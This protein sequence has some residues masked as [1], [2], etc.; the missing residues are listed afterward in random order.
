M[1]IFLQ[2]LRYA[3]RMLAK[4]PGFAVIAVLTLAIGIGANTAIFTV[5]DSVM[6]RP[7]PFHDPSRLVMLSEKSAQFEQ[8]SVSYPNFEDWRAQSHS[9]E[10]LAAFRRDSYTITGGALPEHI[11]GREVS[12]GFFSLLG[13]T[14][15]LGRDFRAEEDLQGAAPV[16]ILSYGLWQRRFGGDPGVLG[17][18]VNLSDTS[19]TVVGVLPHDFWFYSGADVFVPIGA[20]KAMWIHNRQMRN[21]MHA[22]AR[23]KPGVTLAQSRAEMDN[24]GRQLAA[25]YPDAN[26]RNGVSVLSVLEDVVSD[27]RGTLFLLFGA[28]GFLLLI[29]CVN[30]ANLLLSRVTPRQR[31]LA[32][33]SALGASTRRV[34]RQ[35]LTESVLLSLLGG[36]LG[37]GFAWLGTRLLVAAVPGTLPRAETIGMD[38]RVALFMLGLCFLTGI[39]FGMAPAWHAVRGN[40]SESLKE[41]GR[42]ASRSSHRVQNVLVVSELA[43]ALVLLVGAGLTIRTLQKLANVDPGFRSHDVLVFNAA[44]SQLR[45]NQP[46]KVRTLLHQV[47]DR[48]EKTPGFDAAAMTTDVVMRDDSEMNFYVTSRPKP[49]PQDMPWSMLYFTT[50]DYPQTMGLRL[51][52]GRFFSER[53]NL[54][55]PAVVVIDEEFARS[56]FPGQD[57]I[58]QHLA[59]PFP[60]LD[61]PR[62]IVGIVD[63]VKQWGLAQ[64]STA[65][66]R[67]QLYMPFLQVP[68][69]FYNLL[70]QM[71]FIV[72][73][74]LDPHAAT[75]AASE[76]IRA[77]DSDIPIYEVET[78]DEIIRETIARQRFATLLFGVF[79]AA[80]L[81]LGAIGTYGVLSYSVSQRTHEMGVR[82]ALGAAQRDIL[83]LVI[84][85]GAKLVGI[86]IAIG[87]LGALALSRLLAGLLYGVSSTDPLTFASVSL[88]LVAVSIAACYLPA[89]RATK[90]D[91]ITALRYE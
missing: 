88:V 20:D 17:K 34:V 37:V 30:V 59:L 87:L 48:L 24:V 84:G 31:E 62:E 35:L 13:V 64:D 68:D 29:A 1:G 6:L 83:R 26:G 91:P 79:A 51:L 69:Q 89:R 61:Q 60:G 40:V 75:V 74:G 54:N 22:V 25:A 81:L 33:R 10:G 67:S 65:K 18:S 45:Y 53:D 36:I 19:Y 23:L 58:G 66:I 86:G 28:V 42:G 73:S 56:I 49:P 72:R 47:I 9:F 82:M 7:L 78:M 43:L 77:I 38:W 71:T 50:P 2:D 55:A 85:R 14:P 41:G 27:V 70:T 21:G 32:I 90:V 44:Y 3:L 80:A 63:H 4:N 11:G 76:Q 39:L 52:K 8:M 5:V 57:P 16:V 15:I 12:A 46:E